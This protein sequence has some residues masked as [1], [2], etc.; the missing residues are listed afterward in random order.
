M[1]APA[2]AIAALLIGAGHVSGQA[3]HVTLCISASVSISASAT[4]GRPSTRWIRIAEAT[5]GEEVAGRRVG[6]PEQAEHQPQD[7]R[8]GQ[9]GEPHVFNGRQ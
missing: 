2:L 5:L 7:D 6:S 9:P 1:R 8:P 4:L 3:G